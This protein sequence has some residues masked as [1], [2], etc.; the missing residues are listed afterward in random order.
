MRTDEICG[1]SKERLGKIID[2]R[3]PIGLF[4]TV[5]NGVFVGV[6][7]LTGDAWTEEFHDYWTCRQWLLGCFE[8]WDEEW[9][10]CET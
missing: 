2:T 1:V 5:E 3:Q 8:V 7:N 6:D 4:Y 10:A 9:A